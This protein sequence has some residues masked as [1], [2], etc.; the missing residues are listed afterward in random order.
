MKLKDTFLWG[1]ATASFQ[2]EGGYKEG[3]KGLST[4]DFETDG[5]QVHL[6]GITYRNTDGSK[7]KAAS[8][9]TKAQN[10]P[11]DAKICLEED[12]Y[13][14]SH[15]A[16]DFY[17]HYKEDI[18][19]MAGMNYNVYRFSISWPRIFPTGLEDTPNEQGLAFYEDVIHELEKYGMQ[20]LITICHDEMPAVLANKNNGW[21]SRESIEAYLKYCKVLFER[22]GN[23]CRYWLTF[24]EINAVKGYASVGLRQSEDSMHYQAVHN[25]FLASALAVK[26]GHEMMKEPMF[27][28]MYALSEVYPATCDPQDV[29]KAMQARRES[30]FFTDVMARGYYPNYTHELLQRR[31]TTIHIREEDEKILKEGTLDFISFSYYRSAI[32]SKEDPFG[33]IYQKAN[34]YLKT[35][36]W[37]WPIDPLGLRYCLNELYDRY[38]KPLFIVE[39]GLGANDVIE[40]DGSIHDDYRIDYLKA[41]LQQVMKAVLMDH[42]PV[43]GYTMWGPIDL[44][45][46]S[47]GE[48][49]KRYGHIYVDMDD[50]GNG[51][52]KRIPKKS[53][54]WMKDV[55]ASGGESLWDD[56]KDCSVAKRIIQ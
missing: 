4:H 19:L 17:H 3:G 24:N 12:E 40:E 54:Y 47:T 49:A 37:G 50:K 14:P 23:R 46:L 6:R 43:L 44:V 8:S 56:A 18:A 9:F 51:S 22:F 2:F 26:M 53:Y 41:H 28:A 55:I 32:I 10:I 38:Q 5:T 16:V 29:F 27:G 42:I 11:A 20:P 30:L 35:T 45:S 7:G 33:I 31:N 15:E 13:Y 48:M 36:D 1:G 34:P 39:N 21:S 52:K 25:M